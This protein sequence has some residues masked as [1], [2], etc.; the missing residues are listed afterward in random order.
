MQVDSDQILLVGG[1][2]QGVFTDESFYFN[3][4]TET[5]EKTASLPVETF[6]FAMPTVSDI[7]NNIVYTVDWNKFRVMKFQEQKWTQVL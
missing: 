4:Q 1:Y 5:I 3:A 7:A 6:P 2:A